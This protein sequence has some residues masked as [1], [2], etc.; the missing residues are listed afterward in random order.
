MGVGEASNSLPKDPLEFLD[1]LR[2]AET[3]VTVDSRYNY[4]RD[5]DIPKLISLIDS[6][7]KAAPVMLTV[8]SKIPTEAS[9][10]GDQA[11]YLIVGFWKR[12]YPSELSFSRMSA[13]KKQEIKQW[14]RVWLTTREAQNKA[15]QDDR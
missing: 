4:V 8:S 11:A 9:T 10:V 3:V 15:L 14:Y 12:F 6:E 5:S 2:Q 1:S 7:E 13:S